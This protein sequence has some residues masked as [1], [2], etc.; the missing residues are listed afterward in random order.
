MNRMSVKQLTEGLE[1]LG[2]AGGWEETGCIY[3]KWGQGSTLLPIT[4]A[5]TISTLLLYLWVIFEAG[6]QGLW[7]KCHL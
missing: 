1:V 5:E 6:E 4:A 2:R 7:V 3:L